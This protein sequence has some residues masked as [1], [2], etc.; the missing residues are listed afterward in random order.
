M[1]TRKPFKERKTFEQREKLASEKMAQNPNTVA[2]VVEPALSTLLPSLKRNL[3]L[4]GK[5]CTFGAFLCA[6]RR[7]MKLNPAEGIFLFVDNTIPPMH[8]LMSDLHQKH[9]EPC[10]FLFVVVSKENTF[11]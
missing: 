11:G 4:V 7:E 10:G 9:K 1:K 8:R 2:V 3:F 5:D 6:V